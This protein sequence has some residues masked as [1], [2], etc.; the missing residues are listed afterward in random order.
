LT[1]QGYNAIS[2]E[3]GN[4]PLFARLIF[5]SLAARYAQAL[6]SLEK[7]LDRKLTAIH[8]LGGANRNKLL[9]RLTELRTGLPVEIGQTESSTIGNFAVQL[10]ASD[11]NGQPI[12]PEAIHEWARNLCQQN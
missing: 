8:M 1:R 11:A 4:E 2:D 7:M 5:E 6:A 12:R 3:P 9:V 10:A